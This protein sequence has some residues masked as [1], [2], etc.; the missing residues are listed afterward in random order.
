[1]PA[2]PPLP[3]SIQVHNTLTCKDC[4]DSRQKIF[5]EVM[6]LANGWEDAVRTLAAIGSEE[7]RTA[8]LD[9]AMQI[10]EGKI[11]VYSIQCEIIYQM[12][13]VMQDMIDFKNTKLEA[14]NVTT[15]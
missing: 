15:H 5:T 11:S 6:Q 7:M 2:H 1:M 10:L 8:L 14:T 9:S 4:I 3:E 13:L 12:L